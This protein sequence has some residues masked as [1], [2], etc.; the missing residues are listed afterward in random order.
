MPSRNEIVPMEATLD[1]P[2]AKQHSKSQVYTENVPN[3]KSERVEATPPVR[4]RRRRNAIFEMKRFGADFAFFNLF[5]RDHWL[6]RRVILLV[7][8]RFF[9]RFIVLAIVLNSIILALSDFSVVDKNLNPASPGFTYR[10]GSIVPAT[11]FLNEIVNLSEIPFTSIFTAECLLKII[12]MGFVRSKGAYMRDPWNALDFVVVIASLVAI[13]P[14][15]P[16]VSVI[17]TIR[18]L[19]PLRSLSMIPGM[20]VIISALLKALPALGNVVVLQIFLFFMFSI[21]GNQLFGGDMT[22]RCRLTEFPVRIPVDELNPHGIW[23][24]SNGYLS[25]VLANPEAY[26]CLNAPLLEVESGNFI[27]ETSPWYTAQPCFWPVNPDDTQ[28]CARPSYSGNHQ[29]V[30]GQTCGGNY[31]VFG[32]PRFLNSIVM[33]DALYQD[34]LDY[35]LTTFD[36]IGHSAV[37]FFQVITSEGWTN[38]M[39]MCMDSTQPTIAVLF[40][41]AFVVFDSIF[42]MNLMLAVISDEFNIEEPPCN[43]TLALKKLPE[44]QSRFKPRIPLLYYIAS[45]PVFSTFVMCAIFANTAVLSL[46]HYPV[47]DTMDA[48]LEI[49][50]FA[51]TCVFVAEMV[52]KVAGLGIHLYT[53]DRFNLFD[54]FIVLMGLLEM[55]LSPPSFLSEN[56]PKKG[57]VSSLRSFRL[58]RLFKLARNWKSLRQLLEMVGRALASI[59]NFGVLL[60][61][62]IYVL[63]LV[64]MQFFGNTM[65]FDSNGYPTIYN[66]NDYWS[67]TVP[68]LHFDTFLWSSITVFKIITTDNWNEDMYNVIRSNGMFAGLY[69][70]LLIVFGNF[71]MM[72]LF[73]ALL[74]DKFSLDDTDEDRNVK[75]LARMLTS[76]KITPTPLPTLED[77][78][79][80]HSNLDKTKLEDQLSD[81]SQP[82]NPDKLT[83]HVQS[84]PNISAVPERLKATSSWEIVKLQQLDMSSLLAR[85]IRQ[86]SQFLGAKPKSDEEPNG[87]RDKVKADCSLK[88]TSLFIFTEDSRVR[89]W[90]LKLIVHPYFDS[91]V[92][93]LVTVSSITLAIDNPLQNPESTLATGLKRL[94]TVFAIIFTCEMAVKIAAMGL[95]LHKGAYLRNGWNILDCV[96]VISSL[97]MLAEASSSRHSLKSLRSLRAFRAFRPLRVISRRPGLKLVVNALIEAIPAV[98]NVLIICAL[99]YLMFSIFAVTYLKGRL[100]SCSGDVFNALSDAQVNFLVNPKPW[101]SLSLDQQQ[102]F[103]NTNCIGFPTD[104][105]TSKY[106]CGCWGADWGPVVPQNFNNVGNAMITFFE[107]STTE[108][109]SLLMIACIDATGIDMQPIRDYNMWWAAFFVNFMMFGS[110]FVVNL[111]IGVIINNFNKMTDALGDSFMLTSEQKKWIKAQKAAARVGPQRVFIPFKHPVRRVV[112]FF[113]RHKRFEW[114]IMICIIVN[115]LLMATQYYGQS[116]I[117]ITIVNNLN[118]IFAGIFTCEAMLKIVAYGLV[119]FEDNWNRFDFFVVLGTLVSIVLEALTTAH[120]R[121]F[122]VLARVFRVTRLIR[123]VKASKGVRHILT[124]LY[125]A[126]PGLSNVTSILLLL[127]FIYATMGVQMFAKVGSSDNIDMHANFQSFGR[128]FLFMIRAATGE[129]WDDCMHDFASSP[130]GCVDDPPYD[131]NMCGFSDSDDCVPLNGCGHPIAYLF[132]CSFTLFGTYVMLNVTVAVILDSFSVS[133]EDEE[134]LFDPELLSEFQ[135]KWAK[136]DPKAKGFIPVVKLYAVIALLEPPLVKFEA[137][138]DKNAFLHFMSTL[139][140][141]MYEGDTVYFTDTLLAMTREMVKDDID[142]EL[143]GIGNI[144]LLSVDHPGHHRLHYQAHEYFAVRRIQR[145]VATWLQVK[146]QMEKRSMDEYKNKIKKPTTRPKRHRGSLVVTTG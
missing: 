137:V 106:V 47:S 118:E 56:P 35:G 9:D 70:I 32:N 6:R 24:V 68:R 2:L 64:G 116:T 144:K 125:L 61:I 17:R 135:S 13:L 122:T 139:H 105:L 18:V 23:P 134:P 38:I 88:G 101:S 83:S 115:M 76:A 45:H 92:L 110:F 131:P 21:L 85:I 66:I 138:G 67:G 51:L 124:T 73:L 10:D 78:N 31:D 75:N 86:V 94:D 48:D 98:F 126:L 102:W 41:L 143:E 62:F 97:V 111:F 40:F 33:D 20:R 28:L 50:N 8:H 52:I 79:A 57:S 130:E 114:F 72:N 90:T 136:V 108:N 65:R 142:D 141:P 112:F 53:R 81:S 59:A 54:A 91:V 58:L 96:I 145:S 25:S 3:I 103:A 146:R 89:Q 63:A 120:L 1:P 87:E 60:L 71:I 77:K 15:I 26:R 22:R 107:M 128:G 11:S 121:A 132:F 4:N 133:N 69:T 95:V 84:G 113:V 42:V 123:L 99:F 14:T 74:L 27:K 119:Y 37:T 29:C 34:A 39:Y 16:N 140:L 12:A 43:P 117:H 82:A 129:S 127:L 55:A 109:W 30:S 46:D 49:I 7:S 5:S 44:K 19:R 104:S 100:N 36:S 80:I 93:C